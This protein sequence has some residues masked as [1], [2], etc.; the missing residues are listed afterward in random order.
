[1]AASIAIERVSVYF[2]FG[3][4]RS[5]RGCSHGGYVGRD[6]GWEGEERKWTNGIVR[7]DMGER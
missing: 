6:E 2:G 7:D 5:G 3:V 1:M 4:V